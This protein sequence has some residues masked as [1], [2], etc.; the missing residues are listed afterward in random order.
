MLGFIL[1]LKRSALVAAALTGL[2][3]GY[4]A[5]NIQLENTVYAIGEVNDSMSRRI[6]LDVL[7]AVRIRIPGEYIKLKI[8]SPGG[9]VDQMDKIQ[10]VLEHS[11][12]EVDTEVSKF[13]ASAATVLFALGEKRI[14][15]ADAKLV[16]HR[17]RV[18][19]QV[20]LADAYPLTAAAARQFLANGTLPT[21][22]EASNLEVIK[23]AQ[24][25][26]KGIDVEVLRSVAAD[27]EATDKELI[28]VVAKGSGLSIEFVSSQLIKPLGFRIVQGTEAVKLGLATELKEK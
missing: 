4:M 28:E 9:E 3:G 11:N 12:M 13:A 6:E 24:E 8:N 20:G 25:V 26:L 10:D 2:S 18:H 27:L 14:I 7:E 5:M 17:A 16:Y 23:A 21:S 1:T 22:N 15:A 19:I